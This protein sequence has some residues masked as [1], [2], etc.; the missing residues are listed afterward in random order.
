MMPT[1][2]PNEEVYLLNVSTTNR[3]A[4][5]RANAQTRT[6]LTSPLSYTDETIYLNDISRITDTIVQ[7]VITPSIIDGKYNIGLTSN[8]NVICH[9][10]VH[11]NTTATEVSSSNYKIIIVD[12]APILQISAQVTTGD[13]LTITSLEGRLLYVNGEQIGFGECDLALNT[14]TNLTR[15]ANGTGEQNYIPLYTEVFGLIPNNRM[16][17][18]LYQKT[19]NPIP[20][21]YNPVEGDPLQ[22]AY[23][24]GAD[25]LRTDIS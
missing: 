25:F 1:A 22:I 3:A 15:G 9:L 23:S 24:Q 8:K 7:N 13:D 2:T 16:S 18:V 14:V 5:Y 21:I 4:V 10:I 12:T 6:W 19:W 20:G 17:D 11:N